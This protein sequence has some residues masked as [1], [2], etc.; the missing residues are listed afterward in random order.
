M[1]DNELLMDQLIQ[2]VRNYPALYDTNHMDYMNVRVKLNIWNEIAVKSGF[3]NGKFYIDVINKS[4]YKLN[5]NIPVFLTF[6]ANIDT[7]QVTQIVQWRRYK[8][9]ALRQKV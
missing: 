1:N 6:P 8:F 9:Y 5:L 4:Y 2:E 3:K 7:L